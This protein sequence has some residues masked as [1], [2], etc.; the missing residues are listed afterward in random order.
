MILKSKCSKICIV[1][2]DAGGAEVLASYIA[3]NKLECLYVLSGPA[4]KV[5]ERRLGIVDSLSLEEGI[6][7]CEKIMCGTSWQSDLEWRAISLGRIQGKYS[8]AY[9]DHWVNYK[10]RF[11]RSHNEVIPDEIWVGDKYA[12]KIAKDIFSKVIIKLVPNPYFIDIQNKF[13]EMNH[14]N[15][16]KSNRLDGV[17][18]LFVCE[19]L[20]EHGFQE[21]GDALHWGYTEHDAIRYFIK[22][23]K[24]VFGS[25]D[26]KVI[27]RPHPSESSEKYRWVQKEYPSIAFQDLSTSLVEQVAK[28]D[29][30]VGCESMAMVVGV[31]GGKRVISCIPPSG[32]TCALPQSEIESL[33][34]ILR[35]RVEIND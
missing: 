32:N 22:N 5:F 26:H 10:E 3:Q 27:V 2:H 15:I 14:L 9:L 19:P 18:I 20:S 17:D 16:K 30:V 34:E 12:E 7:E 13:I 29:V 4:I 33:S 8:I 28:S 21:Y 31:L 1:S 23:I 25:G 11:I 24:N 6:S 35:M